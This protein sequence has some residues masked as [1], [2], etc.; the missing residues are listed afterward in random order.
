VIKG[1]VAYAFTSAIGEA[2]FLY[3]IAG[4]QVGREFIEERARAWYEEGKKTASNLFEQAKK[5]LK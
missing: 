3:E 4:V 5:R 2:I 1:G